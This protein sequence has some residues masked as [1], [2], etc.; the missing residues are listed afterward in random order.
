YPLSDI[1]LH[2]RLLKYRLMKSRLI[3][4]TH[5]NKLT[6][7]VP[8]PQHLKTKSIRMKRFILCAAACWIGFAGSAQDNLVHALQAN[9]SE[10]S[11]EKFIFTPVINLETTSVKS[12]GSS[13]TCWSYAGNSSLETEMIRAGRQPVGLSQIYNARCVYIDN[14]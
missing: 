12:Q 6:G 8:L 1:R 5:A 4:Y 11:I 2:L 7:G 14:A 13:G 3:N 9:K 10:K